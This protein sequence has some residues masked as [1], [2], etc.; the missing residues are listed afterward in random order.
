MVAWSG[1]SRYD[2]GVRG[3]VNQETMQGCLEG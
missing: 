2:A 3:G 1:E